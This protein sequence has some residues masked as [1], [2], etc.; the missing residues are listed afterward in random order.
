MNFDIILE[1]LSLLS[2]DSITS[3][4]LHLV[5]VI[6]LF[7]IGIFLAKLVRNIIVKTTN[8]V[9]VENT[10]AIFLSRLAYW[11]I[12]IVFGIACLSIFGVE[13]ASVAAVLGAAG[14]A[15]GLAFQG[16]LSNFAAGFMLVIFR[17]FKIGDT[18]VVEGINGKVIDINFFETVVDAPDKRRLIIPNSK[19]YGSTIQNLTA[20]PMRRV[21]VQVGVSYHADIEKTR[22]VLE[23]A[24][25]AVE[26]KLEDQPSMVIMKSLGDSAVKWEC[27]V[28][29]KPDAFFVIQERLVVSVKKH[30][31]EAGIEIPFP[32]LVVTQRA[33]E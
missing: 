32:Q 9:K 24:C 27:R 28:W 11:A 5:G 7:I 14:L 1:K 4:L 8:K 2:V 18:I 20:N 17:P 3:F 29:A 22:K 19:I 21:E 26:G 12:I 10:V 23:D 15:I 13:T 6:V 33:V 31:D 25:K 16:T 30:L